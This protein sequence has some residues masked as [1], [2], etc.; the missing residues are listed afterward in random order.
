MGLFIVFG[1]ESKAPLTTLS[2]STVAIFIV[3]FL[4]RSLIRKTWESAVLLSIFLTSN[5][6]MFIG[7]RAFWT[8]ETTLFWYLFRIMGL[9]TG[10]LLFIALFAAGDAKTR[11]TFRMSRLDKYVIAYAAC[12]PWQLAMG[13]IRKNPFSLIIGDCYLWASG[14][15]TYAVIRKP[16]VQHKLDDLWH[17]VA[18]IFLWGALYRVS[19]QWVEYIATG[20]LR[21]QGGAMLMFPAAFYFT[22]MV[23]KQPGTRGKLA[24]L[25]SIFC[26]IISLK[27]GPMIS[28]GLSCALTTLVVPGRDKI[29]VAF[30]LVVVVGVVLVAS[31]FSSDTEELSFKNIIERRYESMQADTSVNPLVVRFREATAVFD[32]LQSS[33]S[34][35]NYLSGMGAG[36]E[37]YNPQAAGAGGILDT[38]RGYFHSIHITPIS[39]YFR[40]GIFGLVAAAL[41][42]GGGLLMMLGT[43]RRINQ[44]PQSKRRDLVAAQVWMLAACIDSVKAYGLVAQTLVWLALATMANYQNYSKDEAEDAQETSLAPTDQVSAS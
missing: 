44:V 14:P 2:L 4:V 6:G 42:F 13:L 3:F 38:S 36:A 35:L 20:L 34:F 19:L 24:F 21:V 22:W 37:V 16:G 31:M 17:K 15:L 18:I 33:G 8:Q 43:T 30:G 5:W 9:L 39:I 11:L 7:S 25:V 32:T 29:R 41:T 1:T 26:L 27:R 40:G 12:L 28:L 10:L 23:L